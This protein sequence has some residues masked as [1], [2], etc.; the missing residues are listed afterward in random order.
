MRMLRAEVHRHLRARRRCIAALLV[1]LERLFD[2]LVQTLP[3]RKL[4]RIDDTA[5]AHQPRETAHRV[6]AATEGEEIEVI[7]GMVVIDGKPVA[8]PDVSIE[9][10]AGSAAD[11]AV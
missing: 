6:G 11:H 3:E 4:L 7:P 9:P 8:P 1:Q 10:V 2:R 5:I